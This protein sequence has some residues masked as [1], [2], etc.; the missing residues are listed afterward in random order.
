VTIKPQPG[1]R[2][3][4]PGDIF[5]AA[6][7]IADPTAAQ[8]PPFVPALAA[9]SEIFSNAQASPT[10][11]WYVL[12]MMC[13][14]YT[15][16]IADR[17]VVST[18]LEPIRLEFHLS[19]SGIAFLTGVS[20]AIFY[21]LF[22]FPISWLTDRKSRRNIIAIALFAW[23]VMTAIC[24][25]A[26]TYWQLLGARIGVGVG[27]AGGT[28]AANSII[29]DYFPAHRRPMALTI[30][31]LG[32]P[33][34][35]W[36]GY[37]LAGAI[38]DRYGWRAVFLAL[39]APGIIAAVAVLLTVPE[40]K[41]GCLDAENPETAPSF[42]ATMK[43]LWQQ[44]SAVHVMVAS[45]L[46]ALWGWGLTYWT[47][48]YLMRMYSLS[49]GEAGALTGNAH[50]IGGTAATVF[51][52]WLM[53]RPSMADPR[54]IVRL[55]G[56]GIGLGTLASGVI[57]WTHSLTV[58]RVMFWIFVPTIYF[59]VGPCFGLL[60]NLA[61]CRMRAL[62]CATTL[63]VANLGNLVIAPQAVGLL[64][65]WFAPSSGPDAQSLR[66]AL[67]CLVPTGLWATAHY[68]LATR[69][70]LRD[71]ARAIGCP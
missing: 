14:V 37:N 40:P 49:V 21:V 11:R 50:L 64:S 2:I 24:G 6:A 68:F 43:F 1:A 59:Y 23:S 65:D 8:Q 63:F 66:L 55:L 58:A 17:Y 26:R 20:L 27:E 70:L 53:G 15:L 5:P 31:S 16:S 45:A 9:K 57:F 18:V 56:I 25:L 28:P 30:F 47:P 36:V 13:L 41:R 46:C 22:G 39:G 69:H 51:T 44:R 60:N 29:S 33:I 10:L 62:F 32:A 54:R 3:A 19:D 42:I 61:Q 67:L 52:G 38:A 71:Q 48:M 12:L 35:A 7:L 4:A 34:G